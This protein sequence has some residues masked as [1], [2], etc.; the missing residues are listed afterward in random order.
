MAELH[1]L[2]ETITTRDDLVRF[3]RILLQD[4]RDHGKDWENPTLERYLDALAA[5]TGNMEGYFRNVRKTSAP[6]EP[7]WKLIGYM[8][9]AARIYE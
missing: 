5:W 2:V 6:V 8:L 4:L 7:T 3:I 1:E 9:L